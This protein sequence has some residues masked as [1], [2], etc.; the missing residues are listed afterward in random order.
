MVE[1]ELRL[2]FRRRIVVVAKV[3]S[4]SRCGPQLNRPQLG[5][6]TLSELPVEGVAGRSSLEVRKST[7]WKESNVRKGKP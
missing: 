5:F 4:I 6:N 7:C 3:T 1:L 2:Q